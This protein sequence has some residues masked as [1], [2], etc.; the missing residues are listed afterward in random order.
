[1]KRTYCLTDILVYSVKANDQPFVSILRSCIPNDVHVTK[2]I[3]YY[4]PLGG[5]VFLSKNVLQQSQQYTVYGSFD[6]GAMMILYSTLTLNFAYYD[7]N[8]NI[9]YN[10][11]VTSF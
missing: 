10:I 3:E 6:Y 1:M 4:L 8:C 9:P 7:F 5:K 11:W 2:K